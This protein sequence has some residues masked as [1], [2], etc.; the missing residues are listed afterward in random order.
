MHSVDG[1]NVYNQSVAANDGQ[2]VTSTI[3]SGNYTTAQNVS[4]TVTP[5]DTITNGAF[6]PVML[7]VIWVVLFI[8]MKVW[9]TETAMTSTISF[10]YINTS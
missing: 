9:R 8:T 10:S 4:V 5:N 3:K 7:L 1:I 6:M 2:T